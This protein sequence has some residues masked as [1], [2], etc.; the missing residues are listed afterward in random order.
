M[1]Q[2]GSA[3]GNTFNK[4]GFMAT[5]DIFEVKRYW[6]NRPCNIKH[7]MKPVGTLEYFEEVTKRKF[8]I[9]PHIKKFANY[10]EWKNKK[11]LEI[12]CGI[13]TETK[14]FAHAGAFLTAIDLSE[15]S[16]EITKK[17]L[18]LYSLRAHLYIANAEELS[19]E[20]PAEI[21]DLVYSFGVLHHTPHPERA[22]K[23]IKQFL[24]PK[25]ILRIMVY[26]KISW[27]VLWILLKYGKGQFWK[28]DKLVA[29]YSE[30]N[31][32]CPV[33]F[34]YTPKSIK[35]IL[36]DIGYTVTKISIDHIF[37]YDIN[38]YKQY[39]YRKVWYFRW[40]P[41]TWFKALEKLFG[42]HLLIEAKLKF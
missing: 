35:K 11:V 33:T 28:L 5:P 23:E 21:F 19:H 41:E 9:E 16:L 15:E 30:A 2:L 20:I 32:G 27:K 6:N 10:P 14:E 37:P 26:N 8:F 25:S 36:E 17:R 13:G 29:E 7:S 39:L 42:W 12:G 3:I 1:G 31:Q 34:Y 22:F 24:G 4:E 18:A 38:Y 40:M